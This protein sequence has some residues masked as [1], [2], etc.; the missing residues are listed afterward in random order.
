M[1][2]PTR[3]HTNWQY[4]HDNGRNIF[5]QTETR[6]GHLGK[7]NFPVPGRRHRIPRISRWSGPLSIP[8]VLAACGVQALPSR[9]SREVGTGRVYAL[10]G[11]EGRWSGT[12]RSD[13]PSCDSSTGLMTIRGD[14]FAFDPFQSTMVIH[15][16]ISKLGRIQGN[17]SSTGGNRLPLYASFDGSTDRS[18]AAEQS[19]TIVGT[20]RSGTCRWAVRLQRS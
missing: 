19:I 6:P 3:Q 18:D 5:L 2:G 14:K 20:L 4:S 12:V 1:K 11:L 16:T 9:L 13:D 15:G 17:F 10:A 8:L 7:V